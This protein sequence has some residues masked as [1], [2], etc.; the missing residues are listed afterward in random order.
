MVSV[1]LPT[2]ICGRASN[3]LR[4][5]PHFMGGPAMVSAMFHTLIC[6][7][8]SNGLCHVPHFVGGPIMASNAI[9]SF[10]EFYLQLV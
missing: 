8:A 1:M 9:L 6:G 3:G 10:L 7:S 5:V 4:H 2:S